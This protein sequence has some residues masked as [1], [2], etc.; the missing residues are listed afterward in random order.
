MAPNERGGKEM[1]TDCHVTVILLEIATLH[2]HEQLRY[3]YL[4]SNSKYK[5]GSD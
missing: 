2:W 1:L 3:Y 5:L 4:A